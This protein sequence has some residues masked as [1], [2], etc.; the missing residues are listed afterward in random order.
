MKK[1]AIVIKAAYVDIKNMLD[2]F[3]NIAFDLYLQDAISRAEQNSL[4]SMLNSPDRENWLIAETIIRNK[5]EEH[6]ESI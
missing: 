5:V 6:N 1:K 2:Y 3:K 4:W